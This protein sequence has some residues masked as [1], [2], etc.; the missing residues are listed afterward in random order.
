MSGKWNLKRHIQN[1]HK[2]KEPNLETYSQKFYNLR[3]KEPLLQNV[4]KTVN[5]EDKESWLSLRNDSKTSSL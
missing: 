3:P 5:D 1:V 2:K 4:R